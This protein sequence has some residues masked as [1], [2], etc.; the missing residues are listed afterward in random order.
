[1]C[2]SG[3]IGTNKLSLWVKIFLSY[4][5]TFKECVS[6]HWF[7]SKTDTIEL[8]R[9]YTSHLSQVDQVQRVR[10]A[11]TFWY[12][13][14]CKKSYFPVPSRDVTERTFPG[15]DSRPGRVW[16]VTSRRGTGKSL[17]FFYS[18]LK[19][20]LILTKKN[21]HRQARQGL[22]WHSQGDQGVGHTHKEPTIL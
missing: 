11:W 18:V 2:I 6:L 17:T 15:W 1:M 14:H 22:P 5:T 20:Y 10:E 3:L 7:I 13:I 9:A 12:G 19:E 21:Q 4:S 8:W 16:S